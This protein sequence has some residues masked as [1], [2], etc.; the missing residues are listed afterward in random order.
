M[1]RYRKFGATLW[2]I[3]FAGLAPSAYPASPP[4]IQEGSTPVPLIAKA[5]VI[6]VG[7]STGAVSAAAAARKAG[8]DVFLV[9]AQPYLGEDMLSHLRL[10]NKNQDPSDNRLAGKIFTDQYRYTLPD[11]EI[12]PFTYEADIPSASSHKDNPEKPLLTDGKWINAAFQSVQYNGDVNIIID[13]KSVQKVK[14]VHLFFFHMKDYQLGS[15]TLSASNDKETWLVYGRY[16]NKQP[17]QVTIYDKALSASV[18]DSPAETRYLKLSI[19]RKEGSKRLMLGEIIVARDNEKAD[20]SAMPQVTIVQ[21]L[22]VKR[23][24]EQELIDG[25]VPFL[26]A[27]MPS[28]VLKDKNGEVRGV[29]VDTRNGRMALEGKVIIDATENALVARLAGA[30]FNQ[31]ARQESFFIRY[32][33]GRDITIPT[34]A[35]E[36]VNGTEYQIRKFSGGSGFLRKGNYKLIEYRLKLPEGED[37]RIRMAREQN[38]RNL[39]YDSKQEFAS[40]V[41]FRIPPTHITSREHATSVDQWQK[42]PRLKSLVPKDHPNLMVLGASA[43]L[44]QELAEYLMEP[45]QLIQLGEQ[46]GQFAAD[47]AKKRSDSD[48]TRTASAD[49]KKI[50]S[51]LR[52]QLPPRHPT[53][54]RGMKNIEL[55]GSSVPVLGKYDVVVVGGGTSGAPAAIGAAEGGAKTLVVE[56]LNG[57]GGVGT[58]GAISIYWHGYRKGFTLK[59]EGGK[60]T[61]VLDQRQ[62]WWRSHILKAGADI[63]F[64]AL[65]NAAIVEGNQV[66]GVVITTREGRFCILAD[67][68]VDA[69]GNADIAAAAGAECYF[70][71][72]GP[73]AVQGAGLPPRELGINY[74]NTDFTIIDET[75]IMDTMRAFVSAGR[76][77]KNEFDLGQLIDSRERRRAVGDFTISILDQLNGRTYSDTIAMASSN[78]DTHGYTVHPYFLLRHPGHGVEIVSR[79]PYRAILP[80]GLE[81]LLVIGLGISVERDAIP[82]IRMQPDVQNLGYAAGIAAAAAAKKNGKT[83]SIDLKALQ[84]KLVAIKNIPPETLTEKDSGPASREELEKAVESVKDD[85]Q[86]AACLL[87]N[88]DQALPLLRQAFAKASADNE[89]LIYAHILAVL[90]APNGN[91]R[92]IRE[93][94]A[95]PVWDKGWNYTSM[96]QFGR[97]MS[98]LDSYIFALG[99]S[100][101]PSALP[102]LLKKVK[103]LDAEKE[104]SHFNAVCSALEYI[105]N[106]KAADAL[107]ELLSKPGVGGHSVQDL[108]EALK[109]TAKYPSWTAVTPR[110]SAIREIIIARA[111]Y[112][113][114]DNKEKLGEKTL[115]KYTG[116]IRGHF[117]RHALAVLND[118]AK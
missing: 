32:V 117:A 31:D 115:R 78:Y 118:K 84:Q 116:D 39:T 69:T 64:G 65:S 30:D 87:A 58:Q 23:V 45:V 13:L 29:I 8:A 108:N 79:V 52:I 56:Y 6:I 46:A 98:R 74:N 44:S 81:G 51:N 96:G 72:A 25:G 12:I 55:G 71:D 113:C 77:A 89:K 18:M 33:I 83:R 109:I 76:I 97:N 26:Y 105:G 99:Y 38:A 100:A 35:P 19:R 3:L 103:L 101:D 28:G 37:P 86:G 80:R 9:S 11:D 48:I 20:D 59:V 114:G 67:V 40:D 5:D 50:D 34:G 104:F 93:I 112:R 43:D 2:G 62:E 4:S 60:A 36:T 16:S 17:V 106:P 24:L 111:L 49:S 42:L 7:G 90:G 75:S 14:N 53:V 82:L 47:L 95:A 10:W 57:L 22:H 88:R 27:C 15:V 110:R 41:L 68:V 94:D 70:T 1:E 66:K 92:I 73:L 107:A 91:E 102:C 61:W 85:Y 63:C 54:F 21:P